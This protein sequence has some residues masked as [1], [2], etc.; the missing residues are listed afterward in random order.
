MRLFMFKISAVTGLL[1]I[2]INS[3]LSY[4]LSLISKAALV[5]YGIKALGMPI[6]MTN[7]SIYSFK[8]CCRIRPEILSTVG[9]FFRILFP[10]FFVYVSNNFV[11]WT[12]WICLS[13]EEENVIRRS[14][15]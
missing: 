8:L 12:F 5:K 10:L 1:V 9:S 3:F 14:V 7:A 15:L 13:L 2:L 4:S 6:V 11:T